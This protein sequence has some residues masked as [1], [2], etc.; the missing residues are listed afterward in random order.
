[1]A[2]HMLW[3]FAVE[4]Y[5]KAFLAHKGFAD[6]QLRQPRIRHDLARLRDMCRSEGMDTSADTLVDLLAAK[7]KSSNSA[8]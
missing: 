6:V 7:H 5:S 1:M 4:L 2:F 8:I 3:G